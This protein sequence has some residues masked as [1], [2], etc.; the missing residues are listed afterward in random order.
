MDPLVRS[1][2]KDRQLPLSPSSLRS[3]LAPRG[4]CGDGAGAG[5]INKAEQKMKVGK[6]VRLLFAASF[7]EDNEDFFKSCRK[8][9]HKFLKDAIKRYQ[10]H[11]RL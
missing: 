3:T 9:G 2:N 6:M 10:E 11:R 1:K 8:E 5:S 7:A 4:R